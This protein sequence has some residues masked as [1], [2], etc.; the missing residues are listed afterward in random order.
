MA[1]PNV[2]YG[3]FGDEKVIRTAQGGHPLGQKMELPDG[4]LYR[5]ALVGEAIPAGQLAQSP[6]VIAAHDL[7]LVPQAAAAVGDTSILLTIPTTAITLDQYLGG[8]VNI[9]DGPGEGHRYRIQ[10]HAAVAISGTGTFRLDETVREALTV[11]ASLCGLF[12]NPWNS[13]ILWNTS[14]DGIPTGF[15]TTEVANGE[16]CWLQTRGLGSVWIQGTV[17]VGRQHVPSVNTSGA[18]DPHVSTGDAGHGAFILHG[19]VPDTTDY[20]FGMITIE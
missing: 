7:D 2:H 16:Y 3:S 5:Y 10:G 19:V 14:P 12:A 18:V 15:A 11:A 17:V 9:N 6:L 4:S 13:S 1:F 8:S 20:G